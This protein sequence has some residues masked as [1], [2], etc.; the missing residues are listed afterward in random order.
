MRLARP[1]GQW[2]VVYLPNSSAEENPDYDEVYSLVR[3]ASWAHYQAVRDNPVALGGNGPDWQ[4]LVAAVEQLN[5]L[6]LSNSTEFLRGEPF[7]SPPQHM[8]GLNENYRAID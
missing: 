5:A 1:L 8:P 2:Q 4:A 6:T 3:Y 7:G